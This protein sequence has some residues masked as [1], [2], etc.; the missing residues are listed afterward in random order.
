MT[1]INLRLLPT[2]VYPCVN[3]RHTCYPLSFSRLSH[4]IDLT[5]CTFDPASSS[6]L[7]TFLGLPTF[8]TD[9]EFLSLANYPLFRKHSR[10]TL[11]FVRGVEVIG[12]AIDHRIYAES[13]KIRTLYYLSY[14]PLPSL[15][16]FPPLPPSSRALIDAASL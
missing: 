9:F 3:K 1:C 7:A 2:S 10:T 16:T 11:W 15:P 8:A 6:R 5:Y 14:P 13:R 4:R 12:C